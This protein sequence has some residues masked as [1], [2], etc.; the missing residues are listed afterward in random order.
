[1]I[2]TVHG[3]A[4]SIIVPNNYIINSYQGEHPGDCV[5]KNSIKGEHPGD[6]GFVNTF[7]GGSPGNYSGKS[8]LY[9]VLDEGNTL[10]MATHAPLL[11]IIK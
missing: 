11:S 6:C 10:T 1:M 9:C 4:K 7:G 2:V 3:L 5:S 8:P